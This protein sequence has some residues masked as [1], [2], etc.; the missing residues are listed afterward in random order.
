MIILSVGLQLLVIGVLVRGHYRNYP[1]AFAYSLVLFFTTIIGVSEYAK[2][3]KVTAEMYG[4]VETFRQAILFLVVLSFVD[5]AVKDS[6]LRSRMRLYLLGLALI[7][8]GISWTMHS[9]QPL[10]TQITKLGRDFGLASVGLNLILWSLLISNK[11]KNYQLLLLTG[12]LG[13]QFTGEAIGHSLRQMAIPQRSVELAYLGN[14]VLVG[15]HLL[16]LYVWWEAFRRGDS[17]TAGPKTGRRPYV[18]EAEGAARFNSLPH[19]VS[20]ER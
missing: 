2:L 19:P 18:L 17:I 14:L 5:Y 20:A 12:G 1:I 4:A 11:H 16:R 10:A 13:L 3:G 8:T 7:W 9:G 6:D 15:A